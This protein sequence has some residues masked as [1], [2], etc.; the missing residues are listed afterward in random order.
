M[1]IPLVRVR[2]FTAADRE[3]SRPV[4]VVNDKMA[5]TLFERS[6]IETFDSP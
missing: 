3:R 6:A 1:C 4:V 5:R 2:G